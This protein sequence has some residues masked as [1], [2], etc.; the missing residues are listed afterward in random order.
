MALTE[1]QDADAKYYVL[2]FYRETGAREVHVFRRLWIERSEMAL[3]RED[4]FTETGRIAGTVRYADPGT[5][6][7]QLLPRSITIERPIDGYTLALQFNDWRVN[8]ELDDSVFILTAPPDAKRIILK[9]K[10]NAR[11]ST[12]FAQ[13]A[14]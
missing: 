7:G 13:K 8:P 12:Q 10:R 4:Q 6:D 3:A 11:I 5:F 2:A 9:E 1:E 14:E